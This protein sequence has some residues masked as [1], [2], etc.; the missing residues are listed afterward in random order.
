M[1]KAQHDA[2][3]AGVLHVTC[4]P[5]RSRP[6]NCPLFWRCFCVLCAGVVQSCRT[7][8]DFFSFFPFFPPSERGPQITEAPAS[9]ERGPQSRRTRTSKQEERTRG[10]KAGLRSSTTRCAR[11]RGRGRDRSTPPSPST[12]RRRRAASASTPPV[13]APQGR[14]LRSRDPVLFKWDWLPAF[15]VRNVRHD[16]V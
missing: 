6:P 4:P 3:H 13:H 9:G 8:E 1:I 2:R 15:Q 7:A 11:E 14:G 10:L 16:R 12:R 5:G